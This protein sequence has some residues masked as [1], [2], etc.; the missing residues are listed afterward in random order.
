MLG[1]VALGFTGLWPHRV[2]GPQP[3]TFAPTGIH[4]SAPLPPTCFSSWLR[5]SLDSPSS[6]AWRLHGRC[7]GA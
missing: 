1:S 3:R 6:R 2:P 4:I 7:M 5:A